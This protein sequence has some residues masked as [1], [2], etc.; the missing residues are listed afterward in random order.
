MRKL[1]ASTMISLDGVM[2]APGGPE[3]DP[4]GGF[5]FGGGPVENPVTI[6]RNGRTF[7]YRGQTT[8]RSGAEITVDTARPTV[9]LRLSGMD[10]GSFVLVK[11][12]G[13]ATA[14]AGVQQSSLAALRDAKEMSY[15]KEG[16]ALWIKLF[17]AKG[18]AVGLNPPPSI[19]ASKAKAVAAD[20]GA[21]PGA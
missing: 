13:F 17:P 9:P 5:A 18:P 1:I 2:Q 16:D 20:T 3:E 8:I 4:T 10:D 19:T 14:D 6:S 11:L 12:N 21:K 7:D 15:Y